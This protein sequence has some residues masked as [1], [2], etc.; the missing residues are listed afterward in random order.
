MKTMLAVG[1]LA[2]LGACATMPSA[3]S[4]Q[5]G[6]WVLA[7]WEDGQFYPGVLTGRSGGVYQVTFDDGTEATLRNRQI[8]PYD[9]QIGTVISCQLTEGVM[10]TVTISTM[11][12]STTDLGVVD[13]AG[14]RTATNTGRCRAL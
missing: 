4:M 1:A 2:L 3:R 8:R 12:P 10:T 13:D 7:E 14:V 6:A 11:G 9:W 5:D